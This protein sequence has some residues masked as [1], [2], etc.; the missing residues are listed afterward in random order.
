M[1]SANKNNYTQAYYQSPVEVEYL[2][3][4]VITR[5]TNPYTGNITAPFLFAPHAAQNL[6][7]VLA[8]TRFGALTDSISFSQDVTVKIPVIHA[9]TGDIVSIYS[10]P[11]G[12][13]W[14]F[15]T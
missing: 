4:T 9:H 5:N 12:S 13:S 2:S 1:L 7:E 14:T 8:V 11:D 10:S 6:S 3:G 15:H